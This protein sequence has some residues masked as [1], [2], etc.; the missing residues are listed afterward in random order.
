MCQN[1]SATKVNL[2][3]HH[4]ENQARLWASDIANK[5]FEEIERREILPREAYLMRKD[6]KSTICHVL[7]KEKMSIQK[8]HI[9]NK[10]RFDTEANFVNNYVD[11]LI[12]DHMK[13]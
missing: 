11:R 2:E 5:I 1:E 6:L 10:N 13:K 12:D 9:P 3:N 8:P 4:K 7:V